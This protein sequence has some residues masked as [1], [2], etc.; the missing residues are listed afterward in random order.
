MPYSGNKVARYYLGET[1]EV[2]IELPISKELG[3][4]EHHEYRW[5]T[6]DEAEDL[7]P[8]RLAGVLDWAKRTISGG[9]PLL[10]SPAAMPLMVRWIAR[11]SAR[12]SSPARWRRRSSTCRWFSGSRYGKRLRIER[13][14]VGL[15]ARSVAGR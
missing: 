6:Y 11:S 13:A 2:E 10:R 3:R 14:S 8:P 9:W 1:E 12:R 7:L 4:P 5:V 15:S